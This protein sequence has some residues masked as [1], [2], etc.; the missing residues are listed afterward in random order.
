MAERIGRRGGQ[1]WASYEKSS[2]GQMRPVKSGWSEWPLCGAWPSC[3]D[4]LKPIFAKTDLADVYWRNNRG[5]RSGSR[6]RRWKRQN[7]WFEFSFVCAFALQMMKLRRYLKN[8]SSIWSQAPGSIRLTFASW[9]LGDEIQ[10]L[11]R[12]NFQQTRK[13]RVCSLLTSR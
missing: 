5:R 9:N 1:P 13:F 3:L 8:V 12:N 11:I 6:D 2:N 7:K 10:L 4:W